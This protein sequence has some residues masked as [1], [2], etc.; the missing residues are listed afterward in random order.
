MILKR[1][2]L[3]VVP[4]ARSLSSFYKLSDEHLLLQ[5][6]CK[7]FAE[8]EL[9]PIAGELDRNQI[10]PA[11]QVMANI[12]CDHLNFYQNRLL[13]ISDRKIREAGIIG[14][15]YTKKLWW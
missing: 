10:F 12:P 8:R 1:L 6:T 11:E 14:Y 3:P 2:Q 15:K 4:N 9:K 13:L 7:D 5:K